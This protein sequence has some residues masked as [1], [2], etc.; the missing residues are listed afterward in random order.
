MAPTQ[1]SVLKEILEGLKALKSDQDVLTSSVDAIAGRVNI[2]AGIKEVHDAT[3][4]SQPQNGH[5]PTAESHDHVEVAPAVVESS[6]LPVKK[7]SGTS[8]IILT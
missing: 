5:I 7:S 3:D 4:V 1:E 2:L 6:P 8:R